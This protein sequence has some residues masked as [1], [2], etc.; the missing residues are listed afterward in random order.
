MLQRGAGPHSQVS[1]TRRFSASHPGAHHSFSRKNGSLYSASS[2]KAQILGLS[3]HSSLQPLHP[4]ATEADRE[5][6]LPKA[7][8]NDGT[9]LS[10]PSVQSP[11]PSLHMPPLDEPL[12]VPRP[13]TPPLP[14]PSPAHPPSDR[15]PTPPL[16]PNLA[17]PPPTASPHP[18]TPPLEPPPEAIPRANHLHPTSRPVDNPKTTGLNGDTLTHAFSFE[19]YDA[20]RYVSAT[21][22]QPQPHHPLN[23]RKRK[24][25]ISTSSQS[26]TSEI[27]R[28]GSKSVPTSR[29]GKQKAKRSRIRQSLPPHDHSISERVPFPLPPRPSR[30][31]GNAAP[32]VPDGPIAPS[33]SSAGG[34]SVASRNGAKKNRN[35]KDRPSSLPLG[36]VE[37][38]SMSSISDRSPVTQTVT[39]L[40]N[41]G[42]AFPPAIP[43]HHPIPVSHPVPVDPRI[44][45]DPRFPVDPRMAGGSRVFTDSRA[46][47]KPH[48]LYISRAPIDPDVPLDP[49]TP[50]DPR[51]G[52]PGS[53]PVSRQSTPAPI[54][55]GKPEANHFAQ[56]PTSMH[57]SENK[58]TVVVPPRNYHDKLPAQQ[59]ALSHPGVSYVAANIQSASGLE[60]LQKKPLSQSEAFLAAKAEIEARKFWGNPH[61]HIVNSNVNV[62]G[63]AEGLPRSAGSISVTGH[64]VQPDALADDDNEPKH[65]RLPKHLLALFKMNKGLTDNVTDSATSPD[66]N[67]PKTAMAATAE[68]TTVEPA[69]VEPAVVEPATVEPATVELAVVE[70]TAV[71]PT[72]VEPTAVEPATVDGVTVASSPKMQPIDNAPVAGPSRPSDPKTSQVPLRVEESRELHK[73]PLPLLAGAK[74][75]ARPSAARKKPS[76]SAD[77]GRSPARPPKKRKEGPVTTRK[78]KQA[79]IPPE[80]SHAPPARKSEAQARRKIKQVINISS[81]LFPPSIIEE[82][83]GL[84]IESNFTFK[85]M[86]F[87]RRGEGPDDRKIRDQSS[88]VDP[89]NL[90]AGSRD[91]SLSVSSQTTQPSQPSLERVREPLFLSRSPTPYSESPAQKISSQNGTAVQVKEEA[92]IAFDRPDPA[93]SAHPEAGPSSIG[94]RSAQVDENGVVT[95]N[96]H[97]PDESRALVGPSGADE[98]DELLKRYQLIVDRES[99]PA[100]L[101]IVLSRSSTEGELTDACSSPE[102]PLGSLRFKNLQAWSWRNK[103]HGTLDRLSVVLPISKARRRKL[104]QRG[105]YGTTLS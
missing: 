12:G 63:A 1:A 59:T 25:S 93:V 31:P 91:L 71:E 24:S 75:D 67:L 95:V 6:L 87:G 19:N 72:A 42:S 77:S 73:A 54:T 104:I 10:I 43:V 17:S 69:T 84:P 97:R 39:T 40:P 30:Y 89:E 82:I 32:S 29:R 102:V 13:P 27:N 57:K 14:P 16:P 60:S 21:R 79:P 65:F 96:D 58:G 8:A 53:R 66:V 46:L 64:K 23:P 2:N 28:S 5:E 36:S 48:P 38:R 26:H 94:M 18:P 20:G 105:I 62:S 61:T 78:R 86:D 56:G 85:G 98:A 4:R 90:F 44:T 35:K 70:P 83:G 81:G 15:P 100:S 103:S 37:G 3:E 52:R 50:V 49:R 47:V 33:T 55:N 92:E 22:T 101:D 80:P 76:A 99:T 11:E 68:P 74:P 7:N 88:P 51:T 41:G 9:S 34:D 45:G